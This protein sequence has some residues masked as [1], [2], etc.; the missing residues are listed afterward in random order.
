MTEPLPSLTLRRATPDDAALLAE[1]GERTFRD[2]FA[3][4]NTPDNMAIY[5][6]ASFSPEKQREELSRPDT[7]FLIAEVE[8]RT[9]GYAQLR[10]E[11]SAEGGT[12]LELVRI[13]SAQ[14][15]IGRGVGAALMQAYLDAGS[16]GGHRR[17]VLCVWEHNPHA[18]AFYK[19]WGFQEAG[20]KAFVLGTDVQTDILFERSL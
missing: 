12:Q 1:L 2:T 4:S 13:Y 6:A 15:W 5:L 19:R 3:A 10:V 9:A 7:T 20:T 14:E 17:L 16:A 11:T 8:G 18:I